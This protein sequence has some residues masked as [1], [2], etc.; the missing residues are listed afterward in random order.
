LP[1]RARGGTFQTI[2]LRRICD[3]FRPSRRFHAHPHRMR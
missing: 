3:A 1:R 2:F